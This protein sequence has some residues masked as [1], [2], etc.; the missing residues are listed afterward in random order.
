MGVEARTSRMGH[1]FSPQARL[2][3][4]QNGIIRRQPIFGDVQLWLATMKVCYNLEATLCDNETLKPVPGSSWY[5]L[6]QSD[7]ASKVGTT[8]RMLRFWILNY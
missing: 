7:N 1:L 2:M 5:L 6:C 3:D 8:C 4:I